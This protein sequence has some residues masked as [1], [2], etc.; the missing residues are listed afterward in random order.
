MLGLLVKVVLGLRQR[1]RTRPAPLHGVVV[2]IVVVDIVLFVVLLQRQGT[3]DTGAGGDEGRGVLSTSRR[4]RPQL[5]RQL[6]SERRRDGENSG[7][8]GACVA[9]RRRAHQVVEL[10]LRKVVIQVLLPVRLVHVHFQVVVP[11]EALVAH[12][13]PNAFLVESI[14]LVFVVHVMVL[15]PHI[16]KGGVTH[17]ALVHG[18]GV[19]GSQVVAKWVRAGKAL[20]ANVTTVRRVLVSRAVLL[21]VPVQLL[22][23]FQLQALVESLPANLAHWTQLAAVFPHVV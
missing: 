11:G 12:G 19:R 13:A 3:G 1:G 21:R 15:A 4:R 10:L 16:A 9:S 5:W 2:I 17:V 18:L 7:G 22:V 20:F 8:R 23:L 14:Q 6:R